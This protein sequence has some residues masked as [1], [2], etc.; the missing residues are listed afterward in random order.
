MHTNKPASPA[1][2]AA[3]AA[4]CV[5][6]ARLDLRTLLAV[7]I[8]VTSWGSAFTGIRVGLTAYTPAHLALL[9]YLL[10][11]LA[12]A[13][14]AVLTRMPLPHRRD[15]P[16]FGLLGLLG[17]TFYNLALGY[18]QM[19]IPA[20][21]SSM[22]VASAPV[23]LALMARLL[24][25][26]RLRV[27][28]WL[29]IGLSFAGVTAITLGTGSAVG[30]DPRALV[31]LAA[32]LATSAY[33]LGQKPLLRRYSALQ[34]TA[35]TFWA[36]TLFL[37]PFAGGLWPAVRAAQPRTTLA[38][39]YLGLVPAALG[40]MTWAH[41]LSRLPASVAGSFLY[42]V[43]AMAMLTAWLVLGETPAALALLGGVLVLAGVIIVNRW[44]KASA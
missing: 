19:T 27:W 35:Y 17:I 43:P 4:G 32:A 42:L 31:V 33:S 8:T 39:L 26:E 6:R 21:T 22:L 14:Y 5:K 2:S 40:Y 13:A 10:A 38:I 20:G 12:F 3:P 36:G 15:L 44:G 29:G 1:V 16:A 11:S 30:I 28:G 7:V 34:C 23:W 9:R 24:Q 41:I 37:L 18:G 25:G